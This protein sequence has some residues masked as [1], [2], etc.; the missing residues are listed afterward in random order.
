MATEEVPSNSM[1]LHYPLSV[2]PQIQLKRSASC[3]LHQQQ[4]QRQQRHKTQQQQQQQQQQQHTHTHKTT[5]TTKQN[6]NN[7]K[8]RLTKSAKTSA[9]QPNPKRSLLFSQT[10]SDLS[11]SSRYVGCVLQG[12]R[13][14]ALE[15]RVGVVPK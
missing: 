9:V 15:D 7:N 14:N 2:T 10:L 3:R 8:N 4:Q 11:Q 6:N 13:S 12:F 5:T 1:L